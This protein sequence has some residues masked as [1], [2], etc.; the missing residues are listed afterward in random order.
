MAARCPAHTARQRPAG[1]RYKTGRAKGDGCWIPVSN[2]KQ[3]LQSPTAA[4]HLY[5]L[6]GA[7]VILIDRFQPANIVVGM[8]NQV[9]VQ[10]ALDSARQCEN[11]QDVRWLHKHTVGVGVVKHSEEVFLGERLPILFCSRLCLARQRDEN[12]LRSCGRE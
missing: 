2:R 11:S 12:K 8:R 7:V 9:D 5:V 6:A 3:L 1:N 10:L 4:P